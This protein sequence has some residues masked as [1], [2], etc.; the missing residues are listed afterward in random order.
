MMIF[1]LMVL[2]FLIGGIPFG[3]LAG[4]IAMKDDIRNHGSGNIGATNVARVLGWRWG[5]VVLVLD[6]LKGLCPVLITK[7]VV[8][9]ESDGQLATHAAVLSGLAAVIGHMYPVYLKLRGGKGVATALGV[10]LVLGPIP[11][12]IAFAAFAVVVGITRIVGLGSLIAS[13]V[14][15]VAYFALNYKTA[16]ESNQ[17]SLTAFSL[18]IPA[19]IIWRHR[20]NIRRL[21]HGE[22]KPL[23]P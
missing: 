15:T 1:A 20:S 18:V 6:A 19:L 13:L 7:A 17:I 14:Y 5:S 11:S 16:W 4:R 23:T 12:L 8:T 10:V 9:S 3:Y 2:A 21:I 22:E